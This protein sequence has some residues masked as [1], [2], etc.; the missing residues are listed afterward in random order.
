[1]GVRLVHGYRP[2]GADAGQ[3]TVV[4][5][6]PGAAGDGRMLASDPDSDVIWYNSTGLPSKGEVTILDG[7]A[8]TYR[9]THDPDVPGTDTFVFFAWDGAPIPW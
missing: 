6:E 2:R 9:Y 4:V 7:N 3:T 5:A 1:M 8:G